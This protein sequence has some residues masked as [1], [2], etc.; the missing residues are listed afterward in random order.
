[1]D[2]LTVGTKYVRKVTVQVDLSL[3]LL[4]MLLPGELTDPLGPQPKVSGLN[5]V[6]H[7]FTCIHIH[8]MYVRTPCC[9]P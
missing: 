4:F 1:M 3:M 5:T 2:R 8:N 7:T 9:T 6:K